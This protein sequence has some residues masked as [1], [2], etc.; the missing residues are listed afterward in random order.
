MI[1]IL[2]AFNIVSK[3]SQPTSR[4]PREKLRSYK[5]NIRI[6]GKYTLK[7][8]QG[9]NEKKINSVQQIS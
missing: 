4:P 6:H 3:C 9:Q 7:M 8:E 2:I 5:D 1:N